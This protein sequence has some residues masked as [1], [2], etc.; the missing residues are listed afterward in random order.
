M[1]IGLSWAPSS[2]KTSVVNEL[3]KKGFKIYNEAATQII[4]EEKEKWRKVEDII[5]DANFQYRIHNIK[6][7]QFTDHKEW[8]AFFD[9]TFVDDIAHRKFSWVETVS[10]KKRLQ[11]SRYD[12]MFYLNHPGI[13]E[14]NGIRIE[15][16]DDVQELDT[17]KRDA[18]KEF[19]Y[20]F[21]EV[22]TFTEDQNQLTEKIIK[23]AVSK[24]TD[25]IIERI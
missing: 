24:R 5:Q 7:Q 18:L 14:D 19:W 4:E 9:T 1:K 15:N 25:F 12:V 17:L 16:S 22:P 6:I 13:V 10:I 8:L 20:N 21:I 23:Q 2:G 11:E 3:E